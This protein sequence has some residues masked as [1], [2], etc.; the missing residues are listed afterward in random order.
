MN[1]LIASVK[2]TLAFGFV[3][4]VIGAFASYVLEYWGTHVQMFQS[5]IDE[6]ARP[7][8]FA[9]VSGHVLFAF[10]FALP[11]ALLGG[12]ILSLFAMFI[13]RWS[14]RPHF[15]LW[16]LLGAIAGCIAALIVYG[17]L[18]SFGRPI[19]SSL[20]SGALAAFLLARPLGAWACPTMN[21]SGRAARTSEFRR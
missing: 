17:Y 3:G 16:P 11:A 4:A 12:L 7:T 21:S 10:A 9:L 18:G 5:L 14:K 15:I 13:T 6:Q 2:S 19:I 20:V 8:A 1:K